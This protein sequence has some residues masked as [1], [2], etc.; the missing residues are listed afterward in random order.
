[1]PTFTEV[2]AP[3]AQA[4]SMVNLLA[5][6][7]QP[8][9]AGDDW[10]D[11]LVW[12]SDSCPDWQGFTPCAELDEPPL[13]GTV[14]LVYVMPVGYRTGFDCSTMSGTFPVERARQQAD[15]IASFVAA[16][17][18]WTGTLSKLEPY[19]LPNG[20]AADQVNPHLAS[21]DADVITAIADPMEAMAMLE[22]VTAETTRGGPVYIHGNTALIG[23]VGMNL[24][25]VGN[26]LRTKTGAIVIP[27]AGYPGTGPDGDPENTGWLY[28]TGPVVVRLGAIT[29]DIAPA[30]TTDRPTN[31]RRV[32][33]ERMF[34]VAFDPCSLHAIQV[35]G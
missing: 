32:L 11:G 23:R 35:T 7:Q 14:G 9:E 16:R 27:D 21:A 22:A 26:E 12:L 33:A 4:P 31:R 8:G 10:M 30:S 28:A 6:A 29:S 1:M 19:D 3:V 15:S 24:D 34:G 18:L 13:A 17:E 2:A 20:G 5:S 25:R